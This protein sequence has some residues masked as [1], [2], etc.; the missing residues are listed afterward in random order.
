MIGERP[1]KFGD[2]V[3]CNYDFIEERR[4]YQLAYPK[5]GQYLTVSECLQAMEDPNCFMLFF[6]DL[7]LSIPL[8]AE[9]FELVQTELDGDT[10]LNEAYKIANNL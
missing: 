3:K 10:V 4:R 5:K 8:S 1:F 6:D 9:R 7:R 2:I